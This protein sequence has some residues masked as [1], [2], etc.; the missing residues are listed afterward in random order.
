MA[1]EAGTFFWHSHSG[2]QDLD[3][4]HGSL[5]IRE[6]LSE[7]PSSK[8]YDSDLKSH[9]ILISNWM[10]ESSTEKYPGKI[11]RNADQSSET[12]LINGKGR[13]R[14]TISIDIVFFPR[15]M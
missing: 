13:H 7:D 10:H 4:I 11:F 3:G 12:F 9:V 1:D 14:V 8:L 6:P 15:K 2:F 5:I